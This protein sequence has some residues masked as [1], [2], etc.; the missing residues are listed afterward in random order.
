MKKFLLN[1]RK[2]SGNMKIHPEMRIRW[3]FKWWAY[4]LINRL[5]L[6]TGFVWIGSLTLALC[7]VP[8]ENKLGRWN[9]NPLGQPL[10][11][12]YVNSSQ[13]VR[14]PYENE[15]V[16]VIIL[17]AIDITHRTKEFTW[18]CRLSE[19]KQKKY[20]NLIRFTQITSNLKGATGN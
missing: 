14:V 2:E 9:K 8:F 4:K 13:A 11:D 17:C 20:H 16:L 19:D 12:C 5:G 7:S 3:N 1:E 6:E 10:L 15:R 18:L